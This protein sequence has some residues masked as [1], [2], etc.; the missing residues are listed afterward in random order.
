MRRPATSRKACPLDSRGFALT[1]SLPLIAISIDGVT[2]LFRH[3]RQT[4]SVSVQ[5]QSTDV[6]DMV[7]FSPGTVLVPTQASNGCPVP[8]SALPPNIGAHMLACYVVF[9]LEQHKLKFMLQ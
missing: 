2:L 1:P 8:P 3:F 7:P 4:G 5:A 6:F 9:F